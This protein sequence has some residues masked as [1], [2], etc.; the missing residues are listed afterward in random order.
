MTLVEDA[1]GLEALAG[2][3]DALAVLEVVGPR[4]LVARA[5]RVVEAAARE[6]LCHGTH[7]AMPLML[8]TSRMLLCPR[9]W[10]RH[11]C[12]YDPDAGHV[13][14]AVMPLMLVTSR[15]LLCP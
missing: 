12:C 15:M 9:C 11:A 4:A 14:H 5:V 13:T 1:G 6:A 10:S 7:A 2:G 8:V 3:V